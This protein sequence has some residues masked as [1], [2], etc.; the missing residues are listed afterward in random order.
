MNQLEATQWAE[1]QDVVKV[2]A[3]RDGEEDKFV[4]TVGEYVVTPHIFD[5]QEE[6]T[7]FLDDHFKLTNMDL[8]IIGAMC[9]KLNE[10]KKQQ[11]KNEE[12]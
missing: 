2:R 6:A 9:Q 5:S 12:K 3:M 4:L 8:A 10:T 11:S 7:E 1:S